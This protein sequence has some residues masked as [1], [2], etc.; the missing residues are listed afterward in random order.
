MPPPAVV[1]GI[2][3]GVA[4]GIPASSGNAVADMRLERS[5]TSADTLQ[6]KAAVREFA[7]PRSPTA[8]GGRGGGGGGAARSAATLTIAQDAGMRWR[9]T[10]PSMVERSSDNGQTWI[11]IDLGTG[12]AAI[13][14]GA[15]PSTLTCWLVGRAGLVLRSADGITFARITFPEPLDL[16][17]IV[18]TDLLNATVTAVGGRQFTTANGGLTWTER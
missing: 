9:I 11:A 6:M 10:T 8:A 7:S 1:G 5:I 15:A 17:A 14:N 2:A 4:G 18:A 13:T 12:A 3:G 16:S